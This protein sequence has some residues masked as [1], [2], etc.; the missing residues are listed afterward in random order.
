MEAKLS[1]HNGKQKSGIMKEKKKGEKSNRLSRSK[2][3]EQSRV[4]SLSKSI[5]A[6]KKLAKT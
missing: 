5:S 1:K 3:K 6:I 4:K 2:S